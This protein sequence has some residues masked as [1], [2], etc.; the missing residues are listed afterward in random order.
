MTIQDMIKLKK[1]LGCSNQQIADKAGLPLATVQ[2]IFSGSTTTPRY[3]TRRALEDALSGFVVSEPAAY[4]VSRKEPEKNSRQFSP[5]PGTME[6]YLALPEGARIELI[7]GK[8]YDMA[9]PTFDHQRIAGLLYMN[10]QNHISKNG[11]ACIPSIAPTDVQLDCDDRTMV[12]PDVLVVC[13]RSKI[14]RAGVSGAPDLIVEIV[15]PSNWHMDSV[16]KLRK[17]RKAGVREYW[18]VIPEAKKVLTFVFEKGD[19]FTEYS[20]D[21]PEHN[22]VPVDIWNGKCVVDFGEIYEQIRFLYDAD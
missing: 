14:T 8:F 17:Y 6:E 10:F 19:E 18:M 3:E 1:E 7:D 21:D 11:G 16:I 22:K 4:G 20:F 13:D 12:Q 2:K 15:S 5:R 9:A